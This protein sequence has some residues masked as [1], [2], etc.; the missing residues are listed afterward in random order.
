[1]I[2]CVYIVAR[3]YNPWQKQTQ[4]KQEQSNGKDPRQA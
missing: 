4:P 2:V 1:M 3:A